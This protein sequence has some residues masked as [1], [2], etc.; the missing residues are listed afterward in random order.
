MVKAFTFIDA[1]P[2]EIELALNKPKF[3]ERW[4]NVL[5]PDIIDIQDHY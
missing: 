3:R 5:Q 1:T 2:R 4:D